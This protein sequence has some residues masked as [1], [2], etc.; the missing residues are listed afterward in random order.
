MDVAGAALPRIASGFV[1]PMLVSRGQ[2]PSGAGWVY[3]VKWDGIRGQVAGV[4]GRVTVRSRPGRDCTGCFPELAE[5]PTGLAAR[6]VVLDGE[7]VWLDRDGYPDFAGVRARLAGSRPRGGGCLSFMAF[8]LLSLDGEPLTDLP[9]RERRER[10]EGLGLDGPTWRTPVSFADREPLLR[11]TREQSLEGIVAKRLGSPYT[12]ARRSSAWV[13]HKH[14]RSERLTIIGHAPAGQGGRRLLVAS[15]AGG[16]LRY[17]GVVELG[18]A[19]DEL[20][21]ALAA[22]EQPGCPLDWRRPPST[23]MWV[24]PKLD[25][26]VSCHGRNGTLREAAV[27]AVFVEA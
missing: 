26:E 6:E 10:L 16:H 17:R 2:L 24:A 18:L 4:D 8:D 13:K 14:L 22:L 11:A 1:A 3:E 21:D 9:Y 5:L 20:W 25:V 27:R 7:I 15:E 19:R 12:A 23:V